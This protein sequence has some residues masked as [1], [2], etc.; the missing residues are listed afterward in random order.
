[1]TIVNSSEQYIQDTYRSHNFRTTRQPLNNSFLLAYEIEIM[2]PSTKSL[3][4]V[5][6]IFLISLLCFITD[7]RLLSKTE[8]AIG[9]W[10]VT[11]L[12][13][14]VSLFDSLLFPDPS[15]KLKKKSPS[16]LLSDEDGNHTPTW[17]SK[18]TANK[19][20]ST[21]KCVLSLEHDGAFTLSPIIN[22]TIPTIPERLLPFKK[23]ANKPMPLR[24]QWDLEPTSYCVT[25][26]HYDE[27][28]LISFP[29]ARIWRRKR[30]EGSSVAAV[31]RSRIE[32][33]CRVWGRY[34]CQVVRQLLGYR[35]NR[36]QSRMTHG[37]ILAVRSGSKAIIPSPRWFWWK[38]R[39]IVGSFSGKAIP[40]AW[41]LDFEK[42]LKDD[43]NDE[44]GGWVYKH[45]R[46]VFEGDQ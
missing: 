21:V 3:A 19:E 10:E 35:Q 34:G 24:G 17:L 12:K 29:R 13:Q 7:A 44:T 22:S 28:S 16:Q 40:S 20:A 43:A 46:W 23:K 30:R 41:E 15:L 5:F 1:M 31:E 39:I 25:D 38:R 45:G 8:Q 9:E 32:L 2:S 27:L 42:K 4:K 6:N 33:R 14:H 11:I 37:T 36:G 26:R 18:I